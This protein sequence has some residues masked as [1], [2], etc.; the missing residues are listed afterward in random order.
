MMGAEG[1]DGQEFP[2]R[3]KLVTQ[4]RALAIL[5]LRRSSS[6]TADI[7]HAMTQPSPSRYSHLLLLE[8][9][10]GILN[11]GNRWA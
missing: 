2:S 1:L 4:Q 7:R 11:W 3:V 8:A 6:T 5:P 10:L 9:N